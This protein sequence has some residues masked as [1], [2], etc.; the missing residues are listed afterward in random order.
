MTERPA[1][2]GAPI[3]DWLLSGDAAIA[4]Q[5]RRDLLGDDRPEVQARISREGWGRRFLDCRG[6]GGGWGAGFCTSG[7]TSTHYTL[8]ALKRLQI[9]PETGDLSRIVERIA[10]SHIAKDGGLGHIIGS[11]KSDVCINGLFLAYACYFGISGHLLTSIIDFMLGARLEDGGFN[12]KCNRSGARHSSLHS[13]LSFLEGS[14]E[15]KRAGHCYRLDELQQA[16]ATSQQFILQHRL[17]RSDRTGK[18]INPDFLK[19]P[20]PHHWRYNVLKALDYFRAA[21][22]PYDPRMA[23]GIKQIAARQRPDGTWPRDAALPGKVHFVMEPPRGPSRWNTLC[24]LRIAKAYPAP[25][26]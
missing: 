25:K 14:L 5:T 4:Y 16:I 15:Y 10:E 13:T 21:C 7:W 19:M 11:R 24:A 26:T 18:L 17:F 3:I 8:L 23:D 12:C 20:Y 22:V 6:P 9:A 2:E 1:Q